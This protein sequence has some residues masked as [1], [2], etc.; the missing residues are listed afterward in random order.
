VLTP[1][2]AVVSCCVNAYFSQRLFKS[3]EAGWSAM[4][5][6]YVGKPGLWVGVAE[7]GG[8]DQRLDRRCPFAAAI[9]AGEEPGFASQCDAA[10]GSLGS[11]VGDA[12]VV[13]KAGEGRPAKAC[14]RSPWQSPRGAAYECARPASSSL[15]E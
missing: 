10:Q 5:A 2:I 13:E 15:S 3:G 7:L 1:K 14:N 6:D 8:T 9:G 11:V 12:A 4:Q